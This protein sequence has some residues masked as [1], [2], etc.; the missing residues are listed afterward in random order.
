MHK[1]LNLIKDRGNSFESEVIEL[2]KRKYSQQIIGRFCTAIRDFR[3]NDEVAVLVSLI[4]KFSLDIR[5][6]LKETINK[7]NVLNYFYYLTDINVS[8]NFLFENLE[9]INYE[10]FNSLENIPG[11]TVLAAVYEDLDILKNFN[12]QFVPDGDYYIDGVRRLDR[13]QYR[14]FS[15]FSNI[16]AQSKKVLLQLSEY[17]PDFINRILTSIANFEVSMVSYAKQEGRDKMKQTD[18]TV[19]RAR[20]PDGT[21]AEVIPKDKQ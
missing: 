12:R 9:I 5:K 4:K 8:R 15:G 18:F 3:H 6:Q 19:H 2:L 11:D 21:P 14:K 10:F 17:N 20:K 13:S 7:G 1:A 16:L